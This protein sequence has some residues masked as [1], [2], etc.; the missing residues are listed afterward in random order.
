MPSVVLTMDREIELALVRRLG[1]GDTAAFDAIYGHLHVRLLTFLVRLCRSRD[2]AEDLA[3]ETWLR[4]VGH[5]H[6]LRPDTRL[7][8]WLFTVARN[9]HVSYRRSRFLEDSCTDALIG[10]WPAGSPQASP[11][12]E[13]AASELAARVEA[14]LADL[15]ERLREAVLLVAIEGLAPIEAADIC[16]VSPEAMRQRV[17]RGRALLARAIDRRRPAR[18]P[19]LREVLP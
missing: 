18:R 16:G 7:V 6:R 10:L 14:A 5:A 1:E 2:V 13:T 19:E 8:P 9:L 4:L 11:F 3:E 12:E 15:P 17:S